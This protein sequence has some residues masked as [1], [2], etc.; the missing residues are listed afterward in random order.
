VFSGAFVYRYPS[1]CRVGAF[2]A[3]G[4]SEEVMPVE[5]A[6]AAASLLAATVV[7]EANDGLFCG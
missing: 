2:T 5:P 1:L 4:T 3:S 7:A 6:A